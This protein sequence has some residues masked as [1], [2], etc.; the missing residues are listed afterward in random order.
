MATYPAPTT[1]IVKTT[2]SA[3]EITKAGTNNTMPATMAIFLSVVL[4]MRPGPLAK[5]RKLLERSTHDR[6]RVQA[7]VLLQDSRVQ[8]AEVVRVRQ[9]FT[10]GELGLLQ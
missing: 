10:V 1:I 2:A 7:E 8:A 4:L 6:L 3:G 5:H 9:V